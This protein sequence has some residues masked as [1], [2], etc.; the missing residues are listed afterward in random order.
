MVR[1]M[2]PTKIHCRI[3]E[4]PDR[5]IDPFLCEK[6]DLNGCFTKTQ[7]KISVC[8]PKTAFFSIFS[9]CLIFFS[10][11]FFECCYP[12]VE[13]G[14]VYEKASMGTMRLRERYL[15]ASLSTKLTQRVKLTSLNWKDLW[16]LVGLQS[17]CVAEISLLFN[18]YCCENNSVW[19]PSQQ[20][21]VS[22]S[23]A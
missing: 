6:Y 16:L 9:F 20:F 5:R 22:S 17:P 2:Q 7:Q 15:R 4:F 8:C 19:K 18:S 11:F 21:S 23:C 3:A 14:P 1:T 10:S 12:V 13:N